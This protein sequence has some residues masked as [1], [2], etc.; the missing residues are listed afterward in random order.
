MP[1]TIGKVCL[2]LHVMKGILVV[3]INMEIDG[4]IK[5]N[6]LNSYFI[7][8]RKTVTEVAILERQ[9]ERNIQK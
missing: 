8:Y 7:Q 5:T 1:V 3:A 2:H 9:T 4:C 6:V